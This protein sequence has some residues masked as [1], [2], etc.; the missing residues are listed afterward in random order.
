MGVKLGLV[1]GEKGKYGPFI[2]TP[3][4]TCS[5]M[6]DVPHSIFRFNSGAQKS[7]ATR[8]RMGGGGGT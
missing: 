4:I 3:Y 1:S 6:Q 5:P 7:R 2:C 8:F